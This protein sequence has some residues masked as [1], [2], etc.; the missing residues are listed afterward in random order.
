M[1][2]EERNE[3]TPQTPEET[4][5]TPPE[6]DPEVSEDAEPAAPTGDAPKADA[7]QPAAEAEETAGGDA[8]E[9][10][11]AEAEEAAGGD[12]PEQPAAEAEEA[13]GGD[14]PDQ[15]ASDPAPPGSEAEEAAGEASDQPAGDPDAPGSEAEE[16]SGP[17][18]SAGDDSGE[19]APAPAARSDVKP[20][21]RPP[22]AD[23]E[24]IAI[25]DERELT[26]EERAAKEAE[27]EERAAAEQ[28]A[29]AESSEEPTRREAA[30]VPTDA[31][32]QATGKRKSAIARVV[33][34]SG[35]G[36]FKVNGRELDVYFP[37]PHDR[38]VARQALVTAG[39]ESSVD[40]SVRVHG[41]G[42]AG[43]AGAVRHGIARGL[44]EIEP[45]LRRDLKRRGLLTRD[46]REK[47]RRKAGLKKARKRPQFSKR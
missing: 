6:A 38:T 19:G 40:V 28:A 18:V 13:A 1:A 20:A 42:V 17:D 10:P 35:S 12:A 46:A 25:D 26:A 8:P 41:G 4:E 22:G 31:R 47:E 29:T 39:Y 2:E 44:T 23:L 21:D 36:E 11:A 27:D 9:Q 15:S 3:E 45:E 33:L 37:R 43:Q 30:A 7:E 24:P 14:A 5:A 32:I 16:A 34:T